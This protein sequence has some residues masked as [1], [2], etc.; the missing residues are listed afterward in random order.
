M[1]ATEIIAKKLAAKGS[2]FH[3][4]YYLCLILCAWA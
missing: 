3:K 2:L 4:I 1:A